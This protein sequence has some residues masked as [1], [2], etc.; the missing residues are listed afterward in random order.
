MLD[1]SV[2]ILSYNEEIHIQRC[3]E[4][5]YGLVK[6]I[7]LVD[8]FSTDRTIEIASKYGVQV[9]QN[10]WENN[11]S[12][13]FNWALDYLPIKTKWVLRLDSD[14][15]L[16]AELVQEL[17]DK[18]PGLDDNI[19][20]VVIPLRRIFMNRIINHGTG[21]VMLLRIFQYGKG[22]CEPR[23]MDEHIHLSEGETIEFRYP[24]ADHN[25]NNLVWWTNKH[26]GYAIREAIVLL[27]MELSLSKNRNSDYKFSR[28]SAAK[29]SKKRT[30]ARQYLFWRTLAYFIYRYII[31]MGFLDGKEGFVWH[32]LQGWWYRTLVD[33]KV[34]EIKRVCGTDVDKINEYLK[35]EYSIEI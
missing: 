10:K 32:F 12:K 28:H 5:V 29:K 22:R 13:Q 20:G 6:E 9:F 3:I 7:F 19:T 24:F 21:A 23:L 18:L 17:K 30:Y 31:R 34:Y 1:I 14:E 2:I 25:L 16:T 27:D 4:S 15:Y 8:S 26:R 11:H 35:R 33:A